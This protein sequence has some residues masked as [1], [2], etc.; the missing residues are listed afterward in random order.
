MVCEHDYQ[1]TLANS[2]MY[3]VDFCK[4]CNDERPYIHE[5]YLLGATVKDALGMVIRNHHE[6]HNIVMTL[7][8]RILAL[9][10]QTRCNHLFENMKSHLEC[11][12]CGQK[13]GF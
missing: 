2:G 9:E 7:Q 13:K 12:H 3:Y 8:D 1:K 5:P 11:I 6:L 10:L 4:K